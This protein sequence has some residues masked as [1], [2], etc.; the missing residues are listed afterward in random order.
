MRSFW[1]RSIMITSAPLSP[2]ASCVWRR[3]ACE[4]GRLRHEGGRGHEAQIRD[5]EGVQRRPG[6]ARDTRVADITHDGDRESLEALLALVHGES[7][8]QP[9]GRVRHVRFT[10][11]QH[12]HVGGHVRSHQP[13]HA[14]FG[15]ADHERVHVQV[16][17]GVDRASMLSP[18]TREDSCHLEIDH[19]RP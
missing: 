3:T 9:L 17:Q 10:R 13:E 11:G 8:Q 16:L 1:M 2:V 18:L 7:I 4:L 15:V 19:L 5:T 6:G 14:R 12:A